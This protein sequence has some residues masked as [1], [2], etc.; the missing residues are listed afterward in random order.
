M[1]KKNACKTFKIHVNKKCESNFDKIEICI[2]IICKTNIEF[3]K[4]LFA[5]L[6]TTTNNKSNDLQLKHVVRIIRTIEQTKR[7][8]NRKFAKQLI[9]QLL[10]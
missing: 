9:L 2:M 4:M 5:F 7:L 10:I 1:L 8:Y 6:C 3:E